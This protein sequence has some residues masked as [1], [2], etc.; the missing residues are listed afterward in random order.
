MQHLDHKLM[1]V[2]GNR[3][4]LQPEGKLLPLSFSV[5]GQLWNSPWLDSVS[6]LVSDSNVSD[7]KISEVINSYQVIYKAK[8]YSALQFNTY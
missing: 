6:R 5:M 2:F 8:F 4:K 7:F 1:Y 3:I